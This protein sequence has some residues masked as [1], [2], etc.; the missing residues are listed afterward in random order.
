[1]VVLGEHR[2]PSKQGALKVK[3]NDEY[4][5][6][7]LTQ[8]PESIK[9]RGEQK[10][11]RHKW[12][13]NI[14]EGLTPKLP[15]CRVRLPNKTEAEAA[16]S[17]VM[18]ASKTGLLPAPKGYKHYTRTEPVATRDGEYFIYIGIEEAKE[19]PL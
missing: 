4:E 1:V 12:L 13:Y 6:V 18:H 9:W 14:V 8:L 19:Q 15:I 5:T 2:G 7:L 10:Q 17:S 11:P 3:Q 16:R